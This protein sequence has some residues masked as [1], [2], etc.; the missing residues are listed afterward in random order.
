[1]ASVG[2]LAAAAEERGF[3]AVWIP[4]TDHVA[5]VQA[6]LALQA[7]RRIDVGTN[8]ALAFPR[9]PTITA[10]TA[11]DLDEL[12]AG[13]FVCGLG[14]Q[15]RRI[16]TDRFSAEFDRPAVRMA[17]YVQ[18]MRSVWAM[19]RGARD[20]A[21]FEGEIYRVVH[22]GVT[23]YG[24]LDRPAPRVHVAAVGPLMT[25]A[26]ATH[27]DG[28]LGHP[29]TTPAYLR[30]HVLPRVDAALAEAGR[31]R[32]QLEVGTGVIVCVGDDRDQVVREAR[33]QVAFYGTTP[34]YRAVFAANGHEHMTDLLRTTW[35]RTG[36]DRDAM[37]DAMP[38]DVALHY[39][40][41]G[42]PDEVRD[43]LAEHAGLVDHLVLGGAW[44]KVPPTRV[45][46]NL[47]GLMEAFAR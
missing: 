20:E 42:T 41:A 8:I 9:S 36:G 38:E 15:V 27:A 44:W 29:F 39:A 18:A 16:V 11:D 17:E 24:A 46:E 21:H 25:R 2:A 3:D 34:N 1:M 47:F 4:E 37:V 22:P 23:G 12:G 43:L 13:R 19:R 10:M 14:S 32:A 45:A 28:I 30:D 5:F 7:T 31:D 35:Q 33:G 26:A 40:V 6:A